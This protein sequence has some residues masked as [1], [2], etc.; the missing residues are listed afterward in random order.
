MSIII[1]LYLRRFW[2]SLPFILNIIHFQNSNKMSNGFIASMPIIQSYLWLNNRI[3]RQTHCSMRDKLNSSF[4]KE[5]PKDTF[6]RFRK[7]LPSVTVTLYARYTVQPSRSNHNFS[8]SRNTVSGPFNRTST[9]S[10]S[11]TQNSSFYFII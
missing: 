5:K 4:A 7:I 9:W 8:H 11:M 6:H 10:S 2:R 3:T 1:V